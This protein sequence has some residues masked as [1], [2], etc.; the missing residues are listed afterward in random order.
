MEQ[1][2][3]EKLEAHLASLSPEERAKWLTAADHALQNEHDETH[4]SWKFIRELANWL[5]LG[6]N[7]ALLGG[8][9]H[10]YKMLARKLAAARR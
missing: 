1:Q 5:G 4:P 7:V 8:N 10:Q 2:H 9:F 6:T 3:V